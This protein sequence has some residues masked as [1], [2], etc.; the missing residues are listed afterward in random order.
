M[1]DADRQARVLIVAGSD[2]SGGAGLQADLKTVTALGGYGATAVTALTVQN[3]RGVS[4]VEPVAPDFIRQQMIA[5]L[6][7]I[8]ADVV[9]IGMIGDIAAA[10]TIAATLSEEAAGV[11]IVLDPVLAATS[12]DALAED[13]MTAFLLDRLIPMARLVT[14]NADEAAALC[15]IEVAT[16]DDLAEAGRRLRK[17]GAGAA[18]VKGGHLAGEEVADVLVTADGA[19]VFRHP[20]IETAAGHGTGCT[21]ASAVA[22][23]LAQGLGLGAAVA[24]GIRFVERALRAAPGFGEGAGPLN[25]GV[26]YKEF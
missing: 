5:V 2:P 18:L 7:D 6:E 24:R 8:G 9:K 11:P 16:T 12:G 26:L 17:A 3:T 23:G 25:H 14:P 4:A 22:T 13:G 20:R 1:V 15:G 10:E 21:L 19:D